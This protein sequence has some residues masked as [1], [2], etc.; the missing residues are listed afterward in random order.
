M[1]LIV[2]TVL[3]ISLFELI[4]AQLYSAVIIPYGYCYIHIYFEETKTRA[5]LYI[6]LGVHIF[7]FTWVSSEKVKK[8]NWLWCFSKVF[9]TY[10]TPQ[11]CLTYISFPLYFSSSHSE[12]GLWHGVIIAMEKKMLLWLGSSKAE[13]KKTLNADRVAAQDILNS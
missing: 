2:S 10:N 12:G 6:H 4:M 5:T 11:M 7:L 9:N 13:T 8:V 3:Q 1:T